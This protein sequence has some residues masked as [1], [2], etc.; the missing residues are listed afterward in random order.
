M[1]PQ[2]P[3]WTDI[4]SVVISALTFLT[5]G[6][7]AIQLI[8][9]SRQMHRE[10]ESL[11]VERYWTLMDRRSPSFA[12][13][14]IPVAA[15]RAVIRAYLQLCEDEIDLRSLGR[16]SDAT[17]SFWARSIIDQCSSDGYREELQ[18]CEISEYPRVRELVAGGTGWDPLRHSLL[19]R[20]RHGL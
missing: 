5:I 1:E 17:W 13:D 20:V 10:F 3:N 7:A 4:A 16:V 8:F 19:W 6:V 12:I 14:R 11:Y 9:H 2:P 18:K 15:D